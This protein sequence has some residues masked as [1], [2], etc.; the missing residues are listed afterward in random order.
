MPMGAAAKRTLAAALERVLSA[1]FGDATRMHGEEAGT[2]DGAKDGA[3]R[4]R[5]GEHGHGDWRDGL[6]EALADHAMRLGPLVKRREYEG[7][8]GFDE[9]LR[10]GW[11]QMPRT[12]GRGFSIGV[13]SGRDGFLQ[14]A[15]A[16][17]HGRVFMGADPDMDTHDHDPSLIFG[18]EGTVRIPPKPRMTGRGMR[19][20]APSL[21]RP[22]EAVM[23]GLQPDEA[24]NDPV[25]AMQ[26]GI[27]GRDDSGQMLWLAS[28]LKRNNRYTLEQMRT[29]LPESMRLDLEY[30]DAI[31]IAFLATYLLPRLQG[32]LIG[33]GSGNIFR[34]LNR[35][36]PIGAIRRSVADTVQA[37]AIG[38]RTSGLEEYFADLM[39]EAGALDPIT[40]LEAVH[41]AE[42]LHAYTSSTSGGYYLT[43]D[44][45]LEFSPALS[46]L[47]IEGN[48]NRFANVSALLERN[49]RFGVQPIEDTVT[50]AQAAQI[51]LELL[52]NPALIA[53]KPD[54]R[55][56]GDLLQGDG[57]AA[58]LHLID[59][60]RATAGAISRDHPEPAGATDGPAHDGREASGPQASRTS[61]DARGDG[62]MSPWVYRQALASMLS[63]LR[64]PYRFD[65]GFRANLSG[66]NAAVA[67]T[68][69][70][71]SMMPTSRYDQ[72]TRSWVDLD[73][74]ERARMSAS[75]NLRVGL[76]MAALSFGASTGIERVSLHIDSIGLE[77]AVAQQDSAIATLM[78]QAVEAFDRLRD[79]G[80]SIGSSKADP[81]DGDIHGDPTKARARMDDPRSGHGPRQGDNGDGTS[82][83]DG[84]STSDDATVHDGSDGR[85]VDDTSVDGETDANTDGNADGRAQAA[86]RADRVVSGDDAGASDAGTSDDSA[87]V[88]GASGDHASTDGASATQSSMDRRFEDLMRGVDIPDIDEMTFAAPDG[89]SNTR[90]AADDA[91]DA[92]SGDDGANG[93]REAPG[94]V[95]RGGADGDHARANDPDANQDGPL[96]ALRSNPTVRSMVTVTFSREAFMQ[97]L[98]AD[99][100]AHV[101]DTYRM[102]DAAMHVDEHGGLTPTDAAFNLRDA[103]FSP[104]GAQEEPEFSDTRFD[105]AVARVLGADRASDLS[106][107]RVDLLQRAVSDFHI[108]AA[109]PGTASADK[110][111]RAM[112][113]IDAIGDPELTEF[114]PQVGS[115]LIN[116]GDTPEFDF[117]L[118]GRLDAARLKARDLLF[119]GQLD[120]A[121]E[122]IEAALTRFDQR[123]SNIPGVPRYFN[124]YAERVIYNRLFATPGEQTVL[125]PDNLFYAHMELSDVLAQ[126]K[127]AKRALPHLNALVSYAPAYPLSH[128]KLAVQLAREEDW[129]SARAA[130]LNALRVSLDRNDASYAYYRFAYAAWMRDE[131]DVAA[132]AY[133]MSDHIASGQIAALGGELHELVARAQSQC[134][135]IPGTIEEAQAVL[136]ERNLPVWPH[137][138]A[139]GIVRDAARVCVDH[140]MFVPARTLSVAAARMNDSADGGIDIVQAQFLRSLNT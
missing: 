58:V 136:R 40:G 62:P 37:R 102:F 113:I 43:W 31:T 95:G 65:V 139:A 49:A 57:K 12:A 96:S 138:E 124:S 36:A 76:M 23:R 4:T 137:T 128:M 26:G 82:T 35:E 83:S 120:Q 117:P 75:Y 123:F 13:F 118:A 55:L 127:G 19:D 33:F 2:E 111:R 24:S 3:T 27:V 112:G 71:V 72:A 78:G 17:D 129:D 9:D 134:V 126:L 100:L 45:S 87:T 61:L 11:A 60:A 110:A 34:R 114:A 38:M 18:N 98:H 22:I 133:M 115:A 90:P 15:L 30:R 67:F 1:A 109:E 92:A 94:D 135:R 86:S 80:A 51:D 29:E 119:S 42:P 68:T 116:G 77:E 8:A 44:A 25:D 16:D 50:R 84:A 106:I 64:L 28:W 122:L 89:E 56:T 7:F 131:L 63:G 6:A 41:G 108:I 105:G 66:G 93:A 47:R 48:L 69:A 107:Q 132:A 53:L 121:I 10:P 52:R 79:P 59:A 85:S 54:E 20:A 73:E 46:A 104:L 32:L 140:G 101:V 103:R 74:P 125:I 99:G 14:L 130:C 39:R 91:S 97:R 88:D 5:G 21:L 70:G 81:K